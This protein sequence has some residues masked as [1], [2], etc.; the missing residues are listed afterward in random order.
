MGGTTDV[1]SQAGAGG[2]SASCQAATVTTWTRDFADLI[3]DTDI[4]A[5]YE[6]KGFEYT[7]GIV[8][9]AV[10]KAYEKTKDERYQ[11]YVK[12][13]V[14]GF[15]DAGGSLDLGARETEY[16]L[17]VIQPSVNVLAV[18][19]W[20]KEDKYKT[21]LVT[22]RARFAELKKGSQGGFEHKPDR[23]QEMWADGM[24]M[25][26]PFLTGYGR[27]FGD[28][29]AFDL[30]TQQLT[31][32]GE[33]ATDSTSGLV[34]HAWDQDCNGSG[35]GA[36]QWTPLPGTCTSPVVWSR[37]MGWYMAALIEVLG[38]LPA[39]H[40]Q[41]AALLG[42][43]H[44]CAD[45]LK[46]NQS[47]SGLWFQVVDQGTDAA[48]WLET[49]GSGLFVYSLKAAVDRGYLDASYCAVARDGWQGLQTKLANG[50]RVQDAVEAM[51]VLPSA[52]AYESKVR[53]SN[54]AHALLAA[55]LA[56]SVFE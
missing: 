32:F 46:K 24:F 14:D 8:V 35:V 49:S 5:S 25:A 12:E 28:S 43:L 33:K 20:T 38:N 50:P 4:A 15:F 9:L 41:R 51:G 54:S 36:D 44:T 37:G 6:A 26:Y 34:F 27:V 11:R 18:Y 48:N 55:V 3:V 45:G 1:S 22:L 39:G 2:T 31:L 19:E 7:P 23:P 30:A 42:A 17:D 21:A 13:W 29:S 53:V 47:S 40:P 56:A 16:T 10:A 52:S